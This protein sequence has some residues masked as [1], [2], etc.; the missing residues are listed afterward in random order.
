MRKTKRSPRV[1]PPTRRGSPQKR[2]KRLRVEVICVGSELLRHRVNTHTVL[3]GRFLAPLGWRIA[4]EHVVGDDRRLMREVFAEAFRR[5]DVVLCAGGLGPTFDDL[6]RDVWA[7]VT[8][9][10]LRLQRDVVDQ[11]REKFRRRGLSMP[12]ENR[13]QG[14]VLEGAEVLANGA[15]T[16]PGQILHLENR[17]VVLL[18]GPGSELAPMMRDD[19]V[20]RLRDRFPGPLAVEKSLHLIGVPESVIDD[21]IRPLVRRF[22]KSGGCAIEWG[23]LA[24]ELT[25][26]VKLRIAGRDKRATDRAARAILPRLRALVQRNVFAEDDQ[27]LES[28]VLDLL[29]K[30]SA[31]LALAESC[32]GGMIAQRLTSVPG[33]SEILDEGLVCYS[34]AS[35][36]RGLGVKR[37]TLDA[38]G[39]VSRETAIEMAVGARKRTR[40]SYAIAVTGVAGPGGGSPEKPVGTVFIS[41]A[42]PKRVVTRRFDFDGDREAVRL[43]STV[44]ALDLLRR[45]LTA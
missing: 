22:A 42:G 9:R 25:I 39:A 2:R 7:A 8:E 27:T 34:N 40:A 5:A 21:R 32:T 29:R 37:R 20:P 36:R 35:K 17:T 15:G 16:A 33:A 23:I 28:V 43:R 11:I 26:T 13:R 12:P 4:R 31:R 6:T 3:L 44:M 14:F 24:S 18:P 38:F 45:Q 1:K 30:R 10:R 41:C 19:V